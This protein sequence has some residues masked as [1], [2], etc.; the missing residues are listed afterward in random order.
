MA[1]ILVIDDDQQVLRLLEVNFE[2]EGYDVITATNGE[3]GLAKLKSGKPDAVVCDVMM[4]GMNGLDVVRTLREDPANA[5]L[6]VIVVS[7]KAQRSDVE[8]GLDAGADEYVTKPFDP[9][10]LLDAVDRLLTARK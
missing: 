3:D 6:P 8:T 9:Q 2:M 4:P 10:D 5:D 7:A 1:R